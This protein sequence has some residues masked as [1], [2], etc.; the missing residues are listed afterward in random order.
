MSS[1][2]NRHFSR[3]SYTPLLLSLTLTA[4][5]GSDDVESPTPE[6][7]PAVSP[8]EA[9]TATPEAATPTPSP[10]DNRRAPFAAVVTS[11][12]SNG[13]LSL[14][15]L[16]SSE[17]ELDL[18][19]V[20]GDT[21]VEGY[22]DQ[23]YLMM[24]SFSGP[25]YL[26]IHKTDQALSLVKKVELGN[27]VNPRDVAFVGNKGYVSLFNGNAVQVFDPATGDLGKKITLS[28]YADA[29]G[30]ANPLAL[31]VVGDTLYVGLARID[32][33]NN[34]LPTAPGYIIAIDTKT[35]EISS[36][37]ETTGN[38][39]SHLYAL[40]DKTLVVSSIGSYGAADGGIEAIDLVQQES[41]GYLFSDETLGVQ[42]KGGFTAAEGLLFMVIDQTLA[43]LEPVNREILPSPEALD[44]LALQSVTHDPNGRLWLGDLDKKL[45]VYDPVSETLLTESGRSFTNESK[46]QLYSLGFVLSPTFQE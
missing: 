13:T 33:T 20:G 26:S 46:Q 39:L 2:F 1:A 22:A 23:L 32:Y 15:H 37:I 10:E 4:C 16:D 18:L 36:A 7:S 43:V 35:D 28:D 25:N 8:T 6:P 11:D 45:W 24:S 12:Y 38:N 40:D 3:V 34:Y 17:S 5:S 29:D 14:L 19:S 41:V 21:L 9:P 27:G 44:E 31:E 42:D 30:D